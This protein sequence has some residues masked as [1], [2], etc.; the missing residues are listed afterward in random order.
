MVTGVS[1]KGTDSVLVPLQQ[2]GSPYSPVA[3]AMKGNYNRLGSIDGIGEDVNTAL[4]LAFFLDNL[5]DGEFVVEQDY[6]RSYGFYPIQTIEHLLSGFER[7]INDY[8]RAAVLNGKPVVFALICRAVWDAVARA[9]P[10]IRETD[11][12]VFRHL[13][14]DAPVAEGIY[15]SSL[16]AVS[17]HLRELSA[18][19]EFIA[20]RGIVWRPPEDPSQHYDEEMRQFLDEA[21]RRFS[22]SAVVLEAVNKYEREVG[23]LLTEE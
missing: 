11:T 19:N 21:R 10:P 16:A 7:N 12:L 18:V 22:D 1:L 3:L 14:K 9:A 8:E 4:V 17:G 15:G 20:G 5:R 6:L 23:D 13:F 2:I